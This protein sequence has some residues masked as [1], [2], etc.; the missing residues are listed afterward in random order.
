MSGKNITREIE[1][2][3]D[4]ILVELPKRDRRL[5]KK[6]TKQ[7]SSPMYDSLDQAQKKMRKL[8][9]LA[10]VNRPLLEDIVSV[11]ASQHGPAG[12][13]GVWPKSM[14]SFLERM[15]NL[16]SDELAGY[17]EIT[18]GNYRNV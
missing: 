17:Q 14:G 6:L 13:T 12:K 9:I 3:A 15:P 2:A 8:Q 16:R 4:K 5:A 11:L 10:A 1:L 18:G 7:M